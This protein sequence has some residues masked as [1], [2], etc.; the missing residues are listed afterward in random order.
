MGADSADNT[1]LLVCSVFAGGELDGFWLELQRR[2]LGQTVGEGRFDH[3]VYL[4][5][6]ADERLFC[7]STVVGRSVRCGHHEHLEGLHCLGD[8][9]VSRRDRYGGFLVLDSDAF[10]ILPG[11]MDILNRQ[12]ARLRRPYAAAVRTENLDVFPH[13]CVVY[14]PTPQSLRFRVRE[15]VNLL[16]RPVRDI[17]CE[18]APCL[19]LLKSNGINLHPVLATVYSGL[20]YH[21]GCGSRSFEMRATNAG[22]Y[23]PSLPAAPTPEALLEILRAGPAAFLAALQDP[24]WPFF[25]ERVS[26]Q[27]AR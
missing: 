26:L 10:P 9:A 16:G 19:P 20:F 4:G 2:Q 21:H 22:Y 13:P 6:N 11:W 7:Q 3:A 8:F 27:N 18:E 25:K 23:D 12:L 5:R 24:V 14:S 17:A 15:T 1:P